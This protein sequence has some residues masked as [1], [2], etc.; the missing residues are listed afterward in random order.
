MVVDAR[1]PSIRPPATLEESLAL[2]F[3]LKRRKVKL[4]NQ[5][6][7]RRLDCLVLL[8]QWVV[9]EEEKEPDVI[10]LASMLLK[11]ENSSQYKAHVRLYH[12]LLVQ[13]HGVWP[14]QILNNLQHQHSNLIQRRLMVILAKPLLI[15]RLAHHITHGQKIHP[16]L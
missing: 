2:S 6:Y 3:M 10:V 7:S 1:Y 14:N 8:N 12:V 15:L 16:D 5:S 9:E 11:M 13:L 4:A